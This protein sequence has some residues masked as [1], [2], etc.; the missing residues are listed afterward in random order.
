MTPASIKDLLQEPP[1]LAGMER[2]VEPPARRGAT[3]AGAVRLRRLEWS[4]VHALAA[5]L[6][7]AYPD[8]RWPDAASC[9]DYLHQ[10]LFDHPWRGLELPSWVAEADGELCGVYALMPRPMRFRGRPILAAVGCQYVVEP[11]HQGLLGLQLAKA[12]MTGPQDLTIADGATEAARRICVGFGGQAPLA[13]NLH[14]VRPL[15]P[16]QFGL[17]LWQRDR[18]SV[19]AAAARPL[20]RAVDAFAARLRPNRFLLEEPEVLETDLDDVGT[21]LDAPT[22]W[23][24][25]RSLQPTYEP[26]ALAWL[27]EQ[28]ARKHSL[29]RLRGRVVRSRRDEGPLGWYLYYEREGDVSEVLQLAAR[30]DATPLV[31][32][33]LLADAW[34]RGATAVRGRLDPLQAQALADCNCWMRMEGPWTVCHSRDPEIAAALARGDAS[35]SRLDGEWWLDFRGVAPAPAAECMHHARTATLGVPV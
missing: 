19:L 30:P 29:G 15:R 16:L 4:D 18:S 26:A 5:L 24:H 23:H 21:M 20:V 10:V 7:R 6:L 13:F 35:F 1:P 12:C 27:L 8:H 34:R 33:C 25:R 32:R 31:L 9:A 17:A 2:L 3:S 22:H 11:R 28:A 14:W